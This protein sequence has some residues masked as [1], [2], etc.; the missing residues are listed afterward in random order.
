MHITNKV[1]HETEVKLGEAH[2]RVKDM[3]VVIKTKEEFIITKQSELDDF[4]KKFI[5]T[6]RRAENLDIKKAGVER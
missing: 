4:E 2:E 1:R 5:D 6:E 3:Q